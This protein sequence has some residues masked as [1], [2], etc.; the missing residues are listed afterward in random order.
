MF[1]V[2]GNFKNL[3]RWVAPTNM[4]LQNSFAHANGEAGCATFSS[5]SPSIPVHLGA[6]HKVW[7]RPFITYAPGGGGVKNAYPASVIL[8]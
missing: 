5:S 8:K 1:H 3:P 2:F 7:G 4:I 6:V